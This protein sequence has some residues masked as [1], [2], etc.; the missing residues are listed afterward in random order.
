MI[1][2]DYDLNVNKR[3]HSGFNNHW[4]TKKNASIIDTAAYLLNQN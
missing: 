4:M 2:N 1:W 3:S